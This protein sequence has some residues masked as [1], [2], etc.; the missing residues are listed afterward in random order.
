M[1]I[2][3]YKSSD[4]SAPVMTGQAGALAGVLD[5]CLVNG[6][7]AKAAAGWGVAFT[8]TNL[9]SYRAAS[10][11]RLYL[12][13]DDTG[14]TTGK[15]TGYEVMT[16]VTTGTGLFPTAL[17]VSGGLF[18][19]KSTTADGTARPWML[20]ADGTFFYLFVYS[21]QT[22]LP[23]SSSSDGFCMFG[24][25][26]SNASGDAYG[27]ILVAQTVATVANGVGA[28][29][30]SLTG[31][32]ASTGHYIP[33]IYTQTGTAQ[34]VAKI[35]A[36][37][38]LNSSPTVMGNDMLAPVFP[39]PVTGGLTLKET[40]IVENSTQPLTRGKIPG[41]YDLL[42]NN[43]SL[44]LAFTN[45]DTIAGTG[46]YAGITYVLVRIFG[47]GVTGYAAIQI[48]GTWA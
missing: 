24:D 47:A 21:A 35:S 42:H 9:R 17:Q 43:T 25:I 20:I 10:G 41:L 30:N 4:A 1:T 15:L 2:T 46:P 16:A 44:A 6:Y 23:S 29:I 48:T 34:A 45:L 39:D 3:V 5:A 37:R 31:F 14:T 18:Q 22:V 19:L 26:I 13:L 11:N 36:T 38:S 28:L 40:F 7:G 32:S 12:A 33:R 8:G 27:T